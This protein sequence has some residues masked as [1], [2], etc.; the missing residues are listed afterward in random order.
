MAE[1]YDDVISRQ[2]GGRFSKSDIQRARYGS[3]LDERRHEQKQAA[4]RVIKFIT[5]L[6]G[7]GGV[8]AEALK[9]LHIGGF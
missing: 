4:F 1:E 3:K 2:P 9:L 8:L 6:G 7:A 5:A